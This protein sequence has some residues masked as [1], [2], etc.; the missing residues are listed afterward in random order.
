MQPTIDEDDE[1]LKQLKVNGS[2]VYE[3]VTTALVELN[4][5]NTNGKSATAELWNFKE[6]RKATLKEGISCVLKQLKLQKKRVVKKLSEQKVHF[7]L[8]S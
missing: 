5:Y 1:K 4:G 7:N 2:E 3:A 8:Y 6:G